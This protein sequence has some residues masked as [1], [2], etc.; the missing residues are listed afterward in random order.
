[1]KRAG[2]FQPGTV[3]VKEKYKL[4]ET[5]ADLWIQIQG[6]WS[7]PNR[8]VEKVRIRLFRRVG[9]GL[10]LSLNIQAQNP[11]EIE[12]FLRYLLLKIHIM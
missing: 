1:M 10:R 3:R 2:L 7:N 12:L 6:F 4:Q 11:S 9:S 8:C 5:R